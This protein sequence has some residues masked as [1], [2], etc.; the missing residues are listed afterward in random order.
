MTN[1]L[2]HQEKS[3]PIT[4]MIQNR[5]KKFQLEKLNENRNKLDKGKSFNCKKV[6]YSNYRKENLINK[7][8]GSQGLKQT[9]SRQNHTSYR[10]VYY[11]EFVQNSMGGNMGM[12]IFDL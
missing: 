5:R 4:L 6:K 10:K 3:T 8:H 7:R 11:N 12:I 1:F 2:N 9:A